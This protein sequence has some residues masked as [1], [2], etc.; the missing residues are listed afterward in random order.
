MIDRYDQLID[1][2][3]LFIENVDRYDRFIDWYDRL[4]DTLDW[5]VEYDWS[6]RSIDW[7]KIADRYDR[8]VDTLDR[9]IFND[10]SGTIN[11]L[12]MLI[13]T[14]DWLTGYDRLIY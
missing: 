3:D 4:I 5:F 6:I 10:L 7:L 14:I 13:D 9:L 12:K 2:I 1:M 11:W 8:L